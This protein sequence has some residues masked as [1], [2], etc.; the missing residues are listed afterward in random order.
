MPDHRQPSCF[1]AGL[2][3][4]TVSSSPPLA[5]SLSSRVLVLAAITAC[6]PVPQKGDCSLR[7][8]R[9]SCIRPSSTKISS[10]AGHCPSSLIPSIKHSCLRSSPLLSGNTTALQSPSCDKPRNFTA[11]AWPIGR[12]LSEYYRLFQEFE[13][14]LSKV[15]VCAA[16]RHSPSGASSLGNGGRAT[17]PSG[18]GRPG[19]AGPGS[20]VGGE[21]EVGLSRPMAALWKRCETL[22]TPPDAPTGAAS[23]A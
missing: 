20:W 16:C 15:M 21:G 7:I 5:T 3:P 23:P 2:P 14:A 12:K 13:V 4:K 8:P 10:S 18:G 17:G 11:L 6:R 22:R 19:F 1:R 9:S